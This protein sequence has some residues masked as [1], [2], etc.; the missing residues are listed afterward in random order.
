LGSI[1][2]HLART[3]AVGAL[4]VATMAGFMLPAMA[5]TAATAH[6]AG[7]HVAASKPNSTISGSPAKWDPTKLTA[8]PITGSCSAT[9]YSFS[10]TNSEKKS[11]TI[12][13]NGGSGT[14]TKLGVIKAGEKA[15]ICGTGSK[16]AKADF[17]IKGSKSV[18][19]VTLS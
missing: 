9:N 13:Y 5:S 19:T 7:D 8:A 17:Y 18:L 2:I 10:I 14:K 16:G 6:M 1:K 3:A 11:E 15:G 12:L 4:G